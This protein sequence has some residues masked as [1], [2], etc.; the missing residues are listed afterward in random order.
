TA[1]SRS[2][3]TL[4]IF[5]A[6]MLTG[7]GSYLSIPVELNPDV[8][9]PIIITTIIHEGISPEDAERLL[10]KPTEIELKSLDG[11]TQISSFSSEN[12]ATIITEFDISF[13]SKTALSDV[14]EAV[15]R[16]KARFPANTEEPLMQEVSA[17]GLPVVQIAIGGQG[18]PE[19]V[20]LRVAE[21]LQR[22][23]EILPQILEAVMVGNREELL[24]AEIDPGKLE[25][26][27]IPNSAIVSTVMNNN[28]LIP[29]G[30][31]DTGQGSFSVKVPG[32]IENAEDLFNLP[33]AST[34]L[35]VLTVADIAKVRRTF[36]DATRYSYSNG[37][38]SISLNVN[39]R[40][41]ANLVESMEQIDAVVER[42]RP[43]LPPSVTLSYINN[44]APLVLEQNLGLQG[45]MATAM[46]L[47]LIV[48][49]ASVGVRSG[50]IVTLAVP[51]SFFFAF[52]IISL[53]GFTYNFMV[54]FGLLLGLG[55]LID[56][57][58]VMVEY[59]DRKMAEG[60]NS[61]EAYRAAVDRM[62]W[63]I[64]ASTATTLAAFLPIMFWPGVSGQF[65]SYL[66]IT[67][68][69]V[70]IGSLFYALLFAPTIGALIGQGSAAAKAF[71]KGGN[72]D[73]RVVATGITRL[74]EKSLKVAVKLPI[75]VFLLSIVTLVTIVWAYGRYGKGVEFFTGVEPSQTQIQVFAR[76]N[77]SPAELRDVMLSVQ[78]RIYEV[79]Y[80]KGIVMQSGTGQQ[81]GGDQQTAP[82]LIGYIFV[83]MVD[84]RERELDGFEVENRYRQAIANLPG[85]RAEVVS[86]E[87]GPPVGKEIQIELSGEELEPLFAEAAR[88]RNFL[89]N[90]MTG[91]IDI[92][93]T[94]PVPGI[95]WEIEVDRARAAMMGA[96]M[97]EIG[98]AIQLM[99][100]GVFMGD[101]R[102]NDSEEEVDIRIRYPAEYRGI[103]QMDTIRIA[104]ANGP[105]PISSFVTRVA[106]PAVSSIQRVDGAR[107]VYVRAN[108]APGI[109]ASNKLIEIDAWL[110]ENPPQ[111]GVTAVFRG[112]N[113]EQANSAAF[114]GKAFSLAMAL[115]AILLVT[116]FNSY[117]QALIILSSV[118]LSTA[119]VLLGL[120]TTGQTFSVILTGI[121]IVAL[122]GIIV[123]N[124]IVLIDTFNYLKAKHGDWTLE[125]IIVQTG[126]QRLRPV[127]LT[128]FTTGFGLLPLAMH[129]SVDLINAEIEVGGP[130]TSQWVSLASAIVFG[131]SFA[132][133]LTLIVT[134]AMLALPDALR[135][136]LRMKA[137]HQP[138]ETNIAVS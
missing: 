95:E 21:Q 110:E 96:S 78:E 30:Q 130:I 17:A 49:I 86:L 7:F 105:V 135:K 92:D 44:T 136:M 93:D 99:T 57:A 16:A 3:T 55:M 85:A 68:F 129:V 123:N 19:R 138:L 20:L 127:F 48:V 28:R 122:S 65:M 74:Y 43:T 72:D 2:R 91:L 10:A 80:F 70:L 39:K 111:R 5:V 114:L 81:L 113:E 23:I 109:V 132:T 79:G 84:R 124:N 69:A 76:G 4:S 126:V 88:I 22:E 58:I 77:Y 61:L 121:G 14:R 120:L 89:E 38:A 71:A 12:A 116:Q 67:V 41:G 63:P 83:E 115:M 54:I 66:P 31:V 101:Y 106:K 50:L 60:L 37:S 128:T 117:Y 18:V 131:L 104:T 64:M 15:N 40:K 47:V 6:I 9:V 62:F 1:V 45:N 87:Q 137:K 118:L 125:E 119:G 90:D 97:A 133:I 107:V 103:E 27:G 100:N 108:P 98:T 52:I 24:E 59:A 32:L 29:A 26:Y 134:P 25:T 36:K 82:D 46:V 73:G 42:I 102:P 56:G 33:L 51:F 35:G 53:L 112:A 34:D 94:A 13:E 75:T 8:E 11:I